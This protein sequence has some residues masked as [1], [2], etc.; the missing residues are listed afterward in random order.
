MSKPAV[1]LFFWFLALALTPVYVLPPGN[2]QPTTFVLVAVIALVGVGWFVPLRP[3]RDLIVACTM[4]ALWVFIVNAWQFFVL[5]DDDPAFVKAI[6]FHGLSMTLVVLTALLAAG[7]PGQF[8]AW[9][10]AG[11]LAGVLVGFAAFGVTLATAPR[12]TGLFDNPNQ[13]AYWAILMGSLWW[14]LRYPGPVPGLWD[15]ALLGMLGV[16]VVESGSRGGMLA[17]GLLVL[18]A[19]IR[20]RSWHWASLALWLALA[21]APVGVGLALQAEHEG[22]ARF[23]Q[24]KKHDSLE[25]RGYDRPLSNPEC[26][27]A[28]CGEGSFADLEDAALGRRETHSGPLT[29]LV[30]YG[31]VGVVAF[32]LV[33][34][35]AMRGAPWGAIWLLAPPLLYNLTHNGLRASPLWIMVGVLA[36]IQMP[37]RQPDLVLRER[38]P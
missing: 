25:G 17:F 20:H 38:V 24:T 36:V 30:S 34:L 23:E 29:I 10:R 35:V 14:L 6:F 22:L 26:L 28:G 12:A 9:T 27:I 19:A 21:G 16:M 37:R 31:G 18:I 13:L 2:P 11:I 8:A 1:P 33:L 5:R 3:N 15:L 7:A 4:A 32:G